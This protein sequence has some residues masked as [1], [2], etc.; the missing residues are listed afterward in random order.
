M[1][2]VYSNTSI[3]KTIT[4]I[5][6]ILI[7]LSGCEKMG[8]H[9]IIVSNKSTHSISVYGEYILPDTLL[10]LTKPFLKEVKVNGARD[11]YD[12]DVNDEAFSRLRSERLTIFVIHTDT[13][14]KY[15]WETIVNEYKILKRYELNYDELARTKFVLYYP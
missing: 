5:I 9:T 2:P 6:G 11:I 1:N 3:M 7:I 10:K 13:L 12:S 15:S 8:K 14:N 4:I